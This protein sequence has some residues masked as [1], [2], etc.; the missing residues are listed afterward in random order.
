M[1][2]HK[3]P[4]TDRSRSSY[5]IGRGQVA[6]P[7]LSFG[8]GMGFHLTVISTSSAHIAAGS[9][10]QPNSDGQQQRHDPDI[11]FGPAHIVHVAPDSP[12]HEQPGDNGS[13][14]IKSFSEPDY[15]LPPSLKRCGIGVAAH[16]PFIFLTL[17]AASSSFRIVDR[18]IGNI[19]QFVNRA[20]S[21]R[22]L[23]D[24]TTMIE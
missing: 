13:R 16:T 8:S 20:I 9:P 15:R 1:G 5:P 12:R 19:F 4:P 7:D 24:D 3:L 11:R 10:Y 17:C 14:P 18:L 21:S 6:A 23:V 22:V 2:Q